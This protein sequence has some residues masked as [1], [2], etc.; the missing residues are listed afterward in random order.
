MIQIKQ[1]FI[2]HKDNLRVIYIMISFI[3]KKKSWPNLPGYM[4]KKVIA[5][6][7][8]WLVFA[9]FGSNNCCQTFTITGNESWSTVFTKLF[10]E[11]DLVR[12]P[13]TI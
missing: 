9:A 5:T 10:F 7:T 8:Q 13:D 1:I 12:R 11:H 3:K 4:E 6:L 2:F